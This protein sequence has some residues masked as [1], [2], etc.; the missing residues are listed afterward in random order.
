MKRICLLVFAFFSLY[1]GALAT[2][3][4]PDILY[5]GGDTL[6]IDCFP[7]EYYFEQIG[8]RPQ[9]LFDSYEGYNTC[10]GRGYRAFWKLQNDSLFLVELESSGSAIPIPLTE[11]FGNKVVSGKPIFADWFSGQLNIRQGERVYSLPNTFS[12]F[13]S[14]KI[15]EIKDGKMT[16]TFVLDNSATR[17]SPYSQDRRLLTDFIQ[18]NIHVPDDLAKDEIVFVLI[19]K[20]DSSGKI[21]EVWPISANDDPFLIEDATQA[22]MAIPSWDVV[23]DHG[24]LA[25]YGGGVNVEYYRPRKFKQ[26]I[27]EYFKNYNPLPK[28]LFPSK[29]DLSAPGLSKSEIL[30]FKCKQANSQNM[31]AQIQIEHYHFD[32]YADCQNAIDTMLA[33]FNEGN[34]LYRYISQQ[35][36]KI[37]PGIWVLSLQDIYALRTRCEDES[38]EWARLLEAFKDEFAGR[39][40]FTLQ[41]VCGKVTPKIWKSER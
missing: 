39:R 14:E 33:H 26:F 8:D 27:N 22:V 1:F 24:I 36:M 32:S 41:S 20:V 9:D 28:P 40:D 18:S 21:I 12:V 13:E 7:L 2:E 37:T 30:S 11:I 6:R 34:E 3:Q 23:Y 25:Q 17:L 5:Y 31:K 16:K 19:R 10:L 38:E 29:I 15:I 35:E 4:C